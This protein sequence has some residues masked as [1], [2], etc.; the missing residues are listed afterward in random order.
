MKRV[1]AGAALAVALLPGAGSASAQDM[2][3]REVQGPHCGG[4]FV[5]SD[6][7]SFRYEG[8]QLYLGGNVRGAGAPEGGA[9]IRLEARSH[10]TGERYVLL[11]CVTPA[12]GGCSAGGSYEAIEHLERGQRLFCI[13]EG[14]GRGRYECGTIKRSRR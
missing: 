9:A 4:R 3:T 13:V 10:I 14:A 1:V 6:N 2:G 11:S 8:G 12:S 5:N 7:C